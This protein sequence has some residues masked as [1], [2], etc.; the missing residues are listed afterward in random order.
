MKLLISSNMQGDEGVV[1]L[2][3]ACIGFGFSKGLDLGLTFGCN[4][5]AGAANYGARLQMKKLEMYLP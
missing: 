1:F 2:V 4:V 3:L 5:W